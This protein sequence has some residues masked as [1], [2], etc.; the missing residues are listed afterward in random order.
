MGNYILMVCA[1]FAL[2]IMSVGFIL[3]TNAV[4]EKYGNQTE[5]K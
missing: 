2:G 1:G 3:E 4:V 5:S